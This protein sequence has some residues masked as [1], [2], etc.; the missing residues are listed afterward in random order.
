MAGNRLHLSLRLKLTKVHGVLEFSQRKWLMPY[1]DYDTY[2]R[3]KAKNSFGR[4]F[5]S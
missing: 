5:L 3:T 4:T 2:M 1:I